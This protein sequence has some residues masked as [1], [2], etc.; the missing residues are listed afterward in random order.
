V[1]G[2]TE[3]ATAILESFARKYRFELAHPDVTIMPPPRPTDRWLAVV[4][5]DK[6]PEGSAGTIGAWNL[7]ELM[8]QLEEI[9]PPEEPGGGPG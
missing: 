9:W 1:T 4:P 6:A 3:R 8:D 5:L 2:G 7:E